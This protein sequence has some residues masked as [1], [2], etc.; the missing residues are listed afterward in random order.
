MVGLRTK[1]SY[2]NVMATIAVF[3][4]LVGGAWAIGKN[5]IGP[6][7]IRPDAVRSSELKTGAVK[8]QDIA[9][10]AVGTDKL[11][12]GGVTTEKLADGAAT[13][14]KVDE[15]SLGEVPSAA[16]ARSTSLYARVAPNGDVIEEDS[17]G[18]TDAMVD[19]AI[20]G[21]Y[22][23]YNTPAFESVQITPRFD[24]ATGAGWSAPQWVT[25]PAFIQTYCTDMGRPAGRGLVFMI[26]LRKADNT[27]DG[28]V[29][30]AGF[31]IWFGS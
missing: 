8:P 26:R 4:A 13:G 17:R 15:A 21:I 29:D 28:T 18:I 24:S 12:D 31:E 3:L 22:C 5:S 2:A 7:Q 23:V 1:L 20:S 10:G 11:A 14:A 9:A 27:F 25:D 6:R 16:T 30:P 19:Q